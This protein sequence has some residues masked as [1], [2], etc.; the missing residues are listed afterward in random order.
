MKI[1]DMLF[2]GI[3]VLL[4]SEGRGVGGHHR[5]ELLVG[6][7]RERTTPIAAFD[8]GFLTQETADTFPI[9]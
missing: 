6:E 1:Q 3:G 9:L 8:Y 7:E 5:I 2:A 4:V